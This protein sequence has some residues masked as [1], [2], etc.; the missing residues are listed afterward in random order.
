MSIVHKLDIVYLVIY[1]ETMRQ[2][3]SK[4]VKTYTDKLCFI[5]CNFTLCEKR[6]TAPS[7]RRENKYSLRL[8]L[9]NTGNWI[10]N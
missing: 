2:D 1:N 4:N 8:T 5:I 3:H 9:Y 6:E 7:T 10:L